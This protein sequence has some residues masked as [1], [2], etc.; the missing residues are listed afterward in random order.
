MLIIYYISYI[1]IGL[2]NKGGVLMSDDKSGISYDNLTHI[3]PD[4]KDY[5]NTV[6]LLEQPFYRTGMSDKEAY[7]ELEY[8]NNNLKSFY[9]GNY[10]P[11]WKQSLHE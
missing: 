8:L 4:Y 6:L 1:K 3:E 5:Y 10:K 9:E 11:L 7:E 2:L